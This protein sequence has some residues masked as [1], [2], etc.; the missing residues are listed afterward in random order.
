MRPQ[1]R[2]A[3]CPGANIDSAPRAR[4]CRRQRRTHMVHGRRA[5]SGRRCGAAAHSYASANLMAAA[6]VM[7]R[8]RVRQSVGVARPK[9][10]APAAALKLAGS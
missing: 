4:L 7:R 2:L 8:R 3:I 9:S 6:R 10:H 5:R 1:P